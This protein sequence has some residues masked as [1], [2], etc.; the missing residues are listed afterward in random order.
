MFLRYGISKPIF[1]TNYELH[2]QKEKSFILVIFLF[3]F[4]ISRLLQLPLALICLNQK[5]CIQS[6]ISMAHAMTLSTN[7]PWLWLIINLFLQIILNLAPIYTHSTSTQNNIKL[8]SVVDNISSNTLNVLFSNV[9]FI[10]EQ[11]IK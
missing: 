6:F 1:Y 11:Y 3:E 7:M 5:Q 8:F 4:Q 9:Y 2:S 10:L